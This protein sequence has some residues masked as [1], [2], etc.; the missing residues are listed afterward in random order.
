MSNQ[1]S[2]E[3][4]RITLAH[5]AARLSKYAVRPLD[6]TLTSR[7]SHHGLKVA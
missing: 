3:G 5:K 1:R 7:H 6:A 4:K 2:P